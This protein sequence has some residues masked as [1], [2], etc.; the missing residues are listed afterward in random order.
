MDCEILL[1]SPSWVTYSPQ[2]QILGRNTTW[3]ETNIDSNWKILPYVLEKNLK[4]LQELKGKDQQ[5]LLILN[6]PSNPTGIKYT[7]SELIELTQICK[8]YG[9][10]VLSDE[11]YGDLYHGDDDYYYSMY[12]LYPENTIV[13]N[14]I[15]K[16]FGAGGWRLGYMILG[17]NFMDRSS[18]FSSVFIASSE[19]HTS[20][21]SPIQHGAIAAFD[22]YQSKETQN[23][24]KCSRKILR[25]LARKFYNLSSNIPG[26]AVTL[27]AEDFIYFL[28]L[29]MLKILKI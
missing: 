1:P 24:M 17:K 19:T 15:S 11:I 21:S 7:L 3:I 20:V 25:N 22:S 2:S 27:P 6:S 10:I 29:Q 16:S 18:I 26:C 8:K 5:F 12:D 9:V 14:G 13:T 23:Y 4:N 28:I